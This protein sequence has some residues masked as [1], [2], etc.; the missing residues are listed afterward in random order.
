MVLDEGIVMEESRGGCGRVRG[1]GGG[2]GHGGDAGTTAAAGIEQGGGEHGGGFLEGHAYSA[3]QNYNRGKKKKFFESLENRFPPT[4][5]RVSDL[6]FWT[7][8]INMTCTVLYDM[9]CIDNKRNNNHETGDHKRIYFMSLY[10]HHRLI[11]FTS[12]S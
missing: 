7:S 6:K 1:G 10:L 12:L 11:I 5:F 9:H 8:I 3:S 2:G 4:K